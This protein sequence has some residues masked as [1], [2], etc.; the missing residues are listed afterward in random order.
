LEGVSDKSLTNVELPL[1]ITLKS[2]ILE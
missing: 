2:K 1:K